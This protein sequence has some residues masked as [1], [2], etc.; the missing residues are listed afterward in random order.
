MSEDAWHLQFQGA[1][2]DRLIALTGAAPL[3]SPTLDARDVV[4]RLAEVEVLL[5][6]WGAPQLDSEALERM[7]RLRAVI[8]CAG[9]VRPIVGGDVWSRGIVV[10]TSADVNAEPVAE[11]TLAAIIMAG[12][13]A[14]FFAADAHRHRE[15]WRY[16]GRRGALGN[17]GLTIGVIGYSRIGRRV[18][19]LARDVLHDVNCLVADPYADAAEVTAAGGTL[20]ELHDMLPRVEILTIHAP[21]LASTHH[22]IGAHELALLPDHACVINTARGSLIDTAA[23]EAECASGRLHAI[24]DVTD[25]EP[26]P[27]SS[28]L[29]DLPNVM[30][31]PHIAGSLGSETLRMTDAALDELAR[32]IDGEPLGRE[33]READMLHIA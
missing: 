32:F 33:I 2:T 7:P 15:D 16:R 30:L 11:Y 10:S 3:W 24:L 20:A 29:Y 28:V 4:G 26:L 6:G 31:T 13:R 14:P 19:R 18:V 12:K 27:A 17:D 8:H 21:E 5:T 1:Q 25:P 9:T 23:L 22:M